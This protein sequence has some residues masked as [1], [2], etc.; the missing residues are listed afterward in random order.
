MSLENIDEFYYELCE[1][2]QSR[3]KLQQKL[4]WYK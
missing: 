1:D 3:E 4:Q 2:K